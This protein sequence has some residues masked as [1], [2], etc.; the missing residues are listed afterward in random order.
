M[1]DTSQGEGWWEASDSRWYPPEDHPDYVD[2]RPPPPVR[3]SAKVD[4]E[5][6]NKDVTSAEKSASSPK[7]KIPSSDAPSEGSDPTLVFLFWGSVV[8]AAT[9][10][11]PWA[12]TREVDFDGID[13]SGSDTLVLFSTS[14]VLAGMGAWGSTSKK[15]AYGVVLG[16]SVV[17][18]LIHALAWSD[19]EQYA[20]S[21]SAQAGSGLVLGAII[22][23]FLVF[24]SF[25]ELANSGNTG[26]KLND[27]KPD[28]DQNRGPIASADHE[29]DPVPGVPSQC[30]E[31]AEDN[32][33]PTESE[34][35]QQQG[36]VSPSGD[37]DALHDR[38][39]A[40]TIAEKLLDV[41]QTP[42]VVSVASSPKRQGTR[43]RWFIVVLALLLVTGLVVGAM[44]VSES[45]DEQALSKRGFSGKLASAE[46]ILSEDLQV[47]LAVFELTEAVNVDYVVAS[48]AAHDQF[49]IEWD[50]TGTSTDFYQA[51]RA[52]S[53]GLA[54]AATSF[55]SAVAPLIDELGATTFE[56]SAVSGISDQ[57]ILHY[58]AWRESAAAWAAATEEWMMG[59]VFYFD[60]VA[61]DY[62]LTEIE[63][64]I[65]KT[66]RELCDNLLTTASA[67][68]G[69]IHERVLHYCDR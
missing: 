2:P 23:A 51:V 47:F 3:S 19:L 10:F 6:D 68:K 12:L 26:V 40:E 39:A 52:W 13:G 4:S 31:P 21:S 50:S 30:V 42:V 20:G 56:T 36:E 22:G 48:E 44:V 35:L 29:P 64:R 58:A 60:D 65:E 46:R 15:V 9:A 59:T 34:T 1:S 14:A 41:E 66:F 18:V 17:A 25:L 11:L 57:A 54:K 33:A 16:C 24:M 38:A 67:V 49:E 27:S 69:D 61:E 53:G 5:E 8:A 7:E 63:D 28:I 45:G 62:N 32:A 55:E 43:L 37:S